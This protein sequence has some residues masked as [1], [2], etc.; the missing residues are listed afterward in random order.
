MHHDGR[1]DAAA[2]PDRR[3][4]PIALTA[5]LNDWQKLIDRA[6]ST[7]RTTCARLGDDA[8][9]VEPATAGIDPIADKMNDWIL[10]QGTRTDACNT[11]QLQGEVVEG[12]RIYGQESN[13]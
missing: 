13:S 9:F 2:A 10:E 11:G 8:R 4:P 6:R 12:P 1:H 3:R 7:T 5:W